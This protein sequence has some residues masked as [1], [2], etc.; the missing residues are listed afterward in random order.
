M[1]ETRRRSV[2][3]QCE[4]TGAFEGGSDQILRQIFFFLLLKLES[5]G[6]RASHLV[7][8]LV[9]HDDNLGH[10]VE[11]GDG[12]EVIHGTLPLLVL[13]LLPHKTHTSTHT[14]PPIDLVSPERRRLESAIAWSLRGTY[15][16]QASVAED[17]EQGVDV[18]LAGEVEAR[19][20]VAARGQHAARVPAGGT[21]KVRMRGGNPLH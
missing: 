15:I 13:L 6:R 14:E 5:G 8:V 4:R 17:A 18:T 7:V 12:A 19:P 9:Q 16:Q 11:F 10:V 2:R 20:N 21:D 3:A 1:C